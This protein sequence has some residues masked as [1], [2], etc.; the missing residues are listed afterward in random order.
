MLDIRHISKTFGKLEVL[1]NVHIGFERGQAVAIIGPNGSGKTTL[2]KSILG[3]VVPERGSIAFQGQTIGQDAGYRRYIGY[4]PQIGRYPDN[5]QIG[6]L[7][8]MM[9][10]LRNDTDT[11]LDEEL[12]HAYRL[13]DIYQKSMRT[14]SGGTRQK[15]SAALAFLFSPPVMIL[16]EPTA[17]LDPLSAEIL[18]EKVQREKQRNKLFLVTSHIMSDLEELATDVLYLVEGRVVFFK[19]LNTLKTET[20]EERLGRAI[21]Q[22]MQTHAS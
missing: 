3:M 12:I 2:I 20:G 16:D 22:I 6:Q 11:T 8:D 15:V 9:R 1:K 17:G 21:A 4:M 18:K 5:M 19:S 7:F 14:L 13:P 10:D